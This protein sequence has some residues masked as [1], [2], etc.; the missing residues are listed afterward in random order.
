M[1]NILKRSLA[2]TYPYDPDYLHVMRHP[3]Q[4]YRCVMIERR[5][6][7]IAP[8]LPQKEVMGAVVQDIRQVLSGETIFHVEIVSD[9]SNH[10]IGWLAV[11]E[12]D[13]NE[14][15]DPEPGFE[16]EWDWEPETE[17]S[18]DEWDNI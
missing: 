10:V 15:T 3:S 13:Y 11:V 17:Y 18:S 1:N 12:R 4:R 8:L 6:P 7:D 9:D 5:L 2:G 16:D 14:E